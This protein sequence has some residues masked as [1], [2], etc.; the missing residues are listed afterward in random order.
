MRCPACAREN[1]P[2]AAW[3]VGCA[4][5]LPVSGPA[6][7]S[8][9]TGAGP[10]GATGA[11]PSESPTLIT[12]AAGATGVT[13]IL[14]RGAVPGGVTT[15][16]RLEPGTP[17]GTRYLIEAI[18]GEGGMGM[19]YK[20]RDLELNRTVALKV[21]KP[22]LASRPEILDRFKREIILAS[23]VTHKNVVR[24]HDLGEVGDLR[25]ISMSFIEGESLRAL[26]DREGPLSPDR[27]VPLVRQIAVALQA[28]H[29]AGIVHRDLKPHNILLDRE[30]QPYIGDFGI[31]RSMDSDGTMTETGAILGTVDYMSPEQAS[32]EVP[33]HRSDIYSLGMMMY[34]MF[35]GTL[36]FRA[37]NALSVMVKR[38]HEDAP[39]V[40]AVR[41]G[42]P[43]WLSAIILRAM[44]RNPAARYQ[45]L[46]D[47][48][49]DLDRQRAS[50][51]AR[52]VRWKRLGAAAAIL[53]A[54]GLIAFGV[55]RFVQS[56]PQAAPAVKTS[57]AVLPF[58]NATGDPRFD[59]VRSG[60]T[61]VV[62]TGLVQAK[63]LRLAGDDRVQEILDLLK[64]AEGEEI[65]PATAQRVG[66]LAG[67]DQVLAGS[68]IKIGDKYRI[69]AS[70]MQI[71]ENG[72]AATKPIVL[73]GADET[74]ILKM[75]DDLTK[76][77]R[78]ELG[79]SR[80]W[81]EKEIGA[82]QLST[83]SVE[84]LSLYGEGLALGRAGNQIEAAKRLEAAVAKDPRFA[85]AQAALAET[86]D[87]LG[88]ADKAKKT[89]DEAVQNLRDVSPWEAAR[90]R[91]TRSRLAGD[92]AGAA[93]ALGSI[94]DAAPNDP[95]SILDLG[96]VQEE[97]GDLPA[98]VTSLQR[99]VTLDPK[100]PGAHYALGRVLFKSGHPTD[101]VA[102]FNK[103]L[104]L[105]GESG[106]EQGRA[107]VLNGLGNAALGTSQLDDA[108]RYFS[109]AL[110][111]RRRI[112]DQRGVAVCLYNLG[113]VNQRRGRYD[114]A[115]R[116]VK[117][118]LQ[119]S[120]AM[121]DQARI[122][123]S[124]AHLGAIYQAAGRPEE[125]LAVFQESLKIMRELGDDSRLAQS[126]RDLGYV[127]LILGKYVEAFFFIKEG[128]EKTRDA[129]DKS[130]LV[131]AYSDIAV[132]E[133]VQ[134]RYEEA[135]KYYSDGL[136]LAKE[137]DNKGAQAVGQVNMAEI[138]ADQ[139]D[140][141]AAF[142]LFSEATG[143]LRKAG[144]ESNLADGLT[145]EGGARLRAGDLEAAGKTLDEAVALAR[146]LKSNATLAEA[147]VYEGG[148]L[149]ALQQ[150]DRSAAVLKEAVSIAAR[151]G[152]FRLIRM[153]RLAQARTARSS[154]D[155]E[156]AL[157]DVEKAGLAPLVAPTLIALARLDLAAGRAGPAQARALKAAEAA[158]RLQQ[159]DCLFQA[160]HLAGAALQKQ[161]RGADALEQLRQALQPLEEMR[162]GL[163]GDA[164]KAFL[165]R[166]ETVEFG[167]DADAALRATGGND[168]ARLEK[169]L[170]P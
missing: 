126:L 103:A 6:G 38:V 14:G 170:T 98:A 31:S 63:A 145:F 108:E 40:T 53:A 68:L 35:T 123:D 13:G 90:I 160:R 71:G 91:A 39:P 10:S 20:A 65:R 62:R 33:D 28:A 169:L 164:L 137:V 92:L 78:D 73:D 25:F 82:A 117:E 61:S 153:A 165:A 142:S 58:H 118:A 121:G 49:R 15:Q 99:A 12:G 26:L 75:M 96:L 23:Q 83:R 42:L 116:L 85:V 48:V 2:G 56:G 22:D 87:A 86:Y 163:K 44:Q 136:A 107:T 97:E 60:V 166:P 95:Q 148:R 130:A 30:G 132:V 139:G 57:L 52:R 36:P 106:N 111:I 143:T 131:L 46:A 141:G 94:V 151:V 5:P 122:A 4:K 29:D 16:Q 7:G 84:A 147:L 150:P 69:D 134:G 11:D 27:G 158:G 51:A 1:L 67:V 101:A 144:S 64:P 17:L 80:A 114:E 138:H 79:V 3:C 70:L 88:Y 157:A 32:G 93:K 112:G 45:S 19:V 37:S 100:H 146:K 89:A 120:T 128:L 149:L 133:Q 105:H 115:I 8:A 74:A 34:E 162:A 110:E 168:R 43:V 50:R 55:V 161:G 156:V 54:A 109:Q 154:R 72:I 102:E 135:L 124:W 152:D 66:R 125:A 9:A 167:R 155:L 159:R 76:R 41:P 24:I 119:V 127:N 47:L 18:L 129:G 81:G 104:A 140:Y 77:V 113:E 59:W 21:I